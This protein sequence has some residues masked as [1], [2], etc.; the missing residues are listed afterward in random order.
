MTKKILIIVVLI[1]VTAGAGFAIQSSDPSPVARESN[2][3]ND[4]PQN[5]SLPG[6]LVV[7]DELRDTVYCGQTI[8]AKRV[9]LD[10]VDVVKGI[11]ELLEKSR[12]EKTHPYEIDYCATFQ[13]EPDSLGVINVTA[14]KCPGSSL[15]CINIG[16][17]EFRV[18]TK[19]MNVFIP[20]YVYYD[21]I[22]T[23]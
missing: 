19:T 4:L 1:S 10:G 18:E 5:E 2:D 3:D 7:H 14:Q 15:Y 6:G 23:I 12:T 16:P 9:I 11:I 22:G 21:Y 20:G 8:R 13:P 17:H